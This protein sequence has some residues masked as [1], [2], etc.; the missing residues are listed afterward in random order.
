MSPDATNSRTSRPLPSVAF[1]RAY[2]VTMRPY[3]LFVSGA[4]GLVGLTFVPQ[5]KTPVFVLVFVSLYLSYGLGQALTDCFQT[6]T[7]AI[8]APYRPLVRGEVTRSRVLGVSLAG[9]TGCAVALAFVNSAVFLPAILAI[10]GLLTYTWLKRRFWGGPPWNAAIVALL[11]IMGRMA[12]HDFTIACLAVLDAHSS[13]AFAFAVGAVFAGYANFVIMGYFKDISADAR[14]GYR[15][16]PVVFGWTT[17]AIV[18]DL[19]AVA[20]A[21]LAFLSLRG[22]T[23][24]PWPA[25][26]VLC[27]AVF[28]NAFAQIGIHI[29]REERASH[30]PIANVVRA[31]VL[32]C[33]AI[34]LA[35]APRLLLFSIAFYALFEAALRR[36][37][38]RSQ[39]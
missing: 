39:I 1:I 19:S 17:A 8:S 25:W 30:A 11:P 31:F 15:T 27:I 16:L 35:Q 24:P 21:S 28:V 26:I 34:V 4:A 38:E 37:P 33:L 23:G 9:L 2:A 20:A 36:R 6:D 32:Y 18:S 3:L 29:T 13:K 7:D 12:D 10:L 5:I 14:T 22:A